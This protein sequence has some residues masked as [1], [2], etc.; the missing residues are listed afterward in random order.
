MDAHEPSSY[1]GNI[2]LTV[3]IIIFIS[4]II[5][6]CITLACCLNHTNC[7]LV[8]NPNDE[9]SGLSRLSKSFNFT[10]RRISEQLNL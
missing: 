8:S 3:V 7:L 6:S 4:L 9:E 10:G 1:S 2:A 5:I